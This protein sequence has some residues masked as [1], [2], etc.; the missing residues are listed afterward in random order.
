MGIAVK[1]SVVLRLVESIRVSLLTLWICLLFAKTS[2][3]F[4]IGD[5][6]ESLKWWLALIDLADS[7]SSGDAD[8]SFKRGLA[9]LGELCASSKFYFDY[10]KQGRRKERQTSEFTF[11]GL[12]MRLRL[13]YVYISFVVLVYIFLADHLDLKKEIMRQTESLFFFLFQLTVI[14]F[15]NIV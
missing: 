1:F 15:C 7:C 5:L 8:S 9:F 11:I 13:K 10:V 2:V 3:S 14:F 4:L 12:W 6:F